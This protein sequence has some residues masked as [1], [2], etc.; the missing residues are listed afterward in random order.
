MEV[1]V[2]QEGQQIRAAAL[3]PNPRS[4]RRQVVPS[5]LGH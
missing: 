4:S 3:G 5:C 1:P 2:R